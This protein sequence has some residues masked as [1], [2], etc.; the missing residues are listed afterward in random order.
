MAWGI[1]SGCMGYPKWLHA[2]PISNRTYAM[3]L[4][5]FFGTVLL[6]FRAP[7]LAVFC[8]HIQHVFPSLLNPY[9]H[10]SN[11]P[12]QFATQGLTR[13]E[14]NACFAHGVPYLQKFEK[15][16]GPGTRPATGAARY[17]LKLIGNTDAASNKHLEKVD[18]YGLIDSWFEYPDPPKVS[19]Y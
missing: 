1:L 11:I 13:A 4:N 16:H 7:A 10:G 19:H 3:A 9:P 18:A 2:L 12:T 17:I 5:L 8:M 14:I 6:R 15:L